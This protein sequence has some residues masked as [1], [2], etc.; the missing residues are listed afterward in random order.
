MSIAL[1]VLLSGVLIAVIV[2]IVLNS[3]ASVPKAIQLLEEIQRE[4]VR[5]TQELREEF[6]QNRSEYN[7]SH[8]QLREELTNSFT[9]LSTS[10][11]TILNGGLENQRRQLESFSAL[12]TGFTSLT[13]TN[14]RNL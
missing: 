6:G 2:L 12:L 5:N 9:Q 3:R 14:L 1:L 10:V 8:R 11:Q 7:Q 4:Q 13:E